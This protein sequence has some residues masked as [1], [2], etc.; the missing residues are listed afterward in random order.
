MPDDLTAEVATAVARGEYESESAAVLGQSRRGRL[1]VH[2][3][4]PNSRR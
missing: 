4:I 1:L 2:D 3:L